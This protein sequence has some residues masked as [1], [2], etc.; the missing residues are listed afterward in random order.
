[1]LT[2][3]ESISLY[4]ELA[5]ILDGAGL[6]WVVGQVGEQVRYGK[7]EEE[8]EVEAIEHVEWPDPLF[9]TPERTE[10]TGTGGRR[11]RRGAK[12]T[13]MQ[14]VPYSPRERLRLMV[15][16]IE[17]VAVH[18]LELEKGITGF[19]AA[20]HDAP[21]EMSFLPE[22][23]DEARG[24][25]IETGTFARR[26][27]HARRLRELLNEIRAEGNLQEVTDAH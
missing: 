19:L 9:G 11:R 14:T 5:R 18:T 23:F 13:L 6:G 10:Q 22:E 12:L 3:A 26:A 27:E 25:S 15:D 2:E 16:A 8:V 20:D 24:F 21:K 4:Q 17:R 7:P 1:M